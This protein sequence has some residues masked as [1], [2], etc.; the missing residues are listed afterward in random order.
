MRTYHKKASDIA[1]LGSLQLCLM[2]TMGLVVGKAF[3][4]G[5]FQCAL[6]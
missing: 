4:E 1:W 6:R 5:H 3:D 2:F